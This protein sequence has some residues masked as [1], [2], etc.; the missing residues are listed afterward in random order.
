M[1]MSIW[2]KIQCFKVLQSA[3][4]FSF[5]EI[6]SSFAGDNTVYN[7]KALLEGLFLTQFAQ[8]WLIAKCCQI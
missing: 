1:Y 6:K 4:P 7:K 3:A 2:M 5:Y 8:D